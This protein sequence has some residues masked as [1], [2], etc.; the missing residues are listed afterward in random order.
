VADAGQIELHLRCRVQPG[1]RAEFLAFLAEAIPFYERPGGITV[2]VLEDEF[3]DH[4][5][6]EKVEY[7]DSAAYER[8]Q[9]RVAHDAKMKAYLSRWRALLATPPVVETYRICAVP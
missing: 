5:F 2:R 6:I 7:A 1:R 4:R 9:Q 3:N 8:D